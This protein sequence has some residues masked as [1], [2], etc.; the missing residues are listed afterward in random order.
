MNSKQSPVGIVFYDDTYSLYDWVTT[1][2]G[3]HTYQILDKSD[4]CFNDF[5]DYEGPH[6]KS[7]YKSEL[8]FATPLEIAKQMSLE[9]MESKEETK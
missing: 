7:F 9:S 5:V 2:D 1:I 8:R 6:N 4:D 3:S